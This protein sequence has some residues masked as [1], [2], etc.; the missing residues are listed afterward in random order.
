MHSS[1]GS[2]RI[3]SQT[4]GTQACFAPISYFIFM[5]MKDEHVKK[6]GCTVGLLNVV[7]FVRVVIKKKV[8]GGAFKL[9]VVSGHQTS[10]NFK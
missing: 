4:L 3:S 1:Q 9:F 8:D 7:D 2:F 10:T 5:S 6:W